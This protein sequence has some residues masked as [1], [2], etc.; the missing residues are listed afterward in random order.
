MLLQ[1]G[2]RLQQSNGAFRMRAIKVLFISLLQSPYQLTPL[3]HTFTKLPRR[4]AN[5]KRGVND[6]I[7]ERHHQDNTRHLTYTESYSRGSR[8]VFSAFHS[9]VVSNSRDY[10]LLVMPGVLDW[11]YQLE[12]QWGGSFR[13]RPCFV[14]VWQWGCNYWFAIS[15]ESHAYCF[16]RCRGNDWCG[17]FCSCNRSLS[18]TV[19]T[20]WPHCVLWGIHLSD[21]VI[22]WLA[23]HDKL[24][25]FYQIKESKISQIDKTIFKMA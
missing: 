11:L 5:T 25:A 10:A 17:C 20:W 22:W 14:S 16:K 24:I 7:V 8:P 15:S 19:K 9:A 2:L 4:S 6:S 3:N 1:R 18:L 13:M 23:L 21:C 12:K